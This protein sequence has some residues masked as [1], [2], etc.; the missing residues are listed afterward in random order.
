MS[1]RDF[2]SALDVTL[3]GSAASGDVSVRCFANPD[4][5][6][7]DDRNP[8]CSVNL[9]TGQWNCHTCGAKGG[10][11]DAAVALGRSRS[12][13]VELAKRHDVFVSDREQTQKPRQPARAAATARPSS[14]AAV[15]TDTTP[16]SETVASE[17]SP[18]LKQQ[19]A[20]WR[21]ALRGSKA[22][23][24]RLYELRGWQPEAIEALGLG[25]DG[26]RI[27]FPVR[28]AARRLVGVL[29]Y[30][31][32]RETRK[33]TKM[34]A[35]KGTP[36]ELFPAPETLPADGPVNVVEGESDV[37]A[38]WS[39]G[40]SRTVGVPGA[41][42]WRAEWA[43]R[44][45]GRDVRLFC[46]LDTPGRKLMARIARD[47]LPHAKSVRIV[48]ME[49]KRDDGHDVGAL[50]AEA[51]AYGPAGLA[52]VRTRIE[53]MADEAV[54]LTPP[55][56]ATSDVATTGRIVTFTPASS[57]RH[58]RVR[59][60]WR[61]RVPLG[62]VTT[63]AGQQ[64]LGKSTTMIELASQVTRGDLDGD[65]HGEP[66]AVL[67]VTLEDHV[68]SVVKPRLLA[69]GADLDRVRI[70]GVT[71]DGQDGLI[72]LPDDLPQIE[73]GVQDCGARLLIVDPVVAAL[74]GGIDAYR[75]HDVRRA[76]APL[77]QLAE[78][79]DLA[80]VAIMH[81]T[82]AQTGDLLGRVSGSVAFTAAARSVLA[83]VRDPDDPEG[84]TGDR[85]V[86]VHVKSNWGRL[87]PSLLARIEERHIDIDPP[88]QA[89]RLVIQGESDLTAADFAGR[90]QDHGDQAD[91]DAAEDLIAEHL[92]DGDWHPA[93]DVETAAKAREISRAA[94]YRAA[95]T[96]ETE[97]TLERQ[98]S[99]FPPR[100]MWRC[101]RSSQ[102]AETNGNTDACD[103]RKTPVTTG[104]LAPLPPRSSHVSDRETNGET[105]GRETIARE[106]LS[107]AEA[108]AWIVRE[109]DAIELP[110][111]CPSH[112]A[113]ARHHRPH[114]DT[115]RVICWKCHPPAWL[116]AANE[117]P[118]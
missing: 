59:W 94:I 118:R 37:V 30:A 100:S 44:F 33:G 107:E 75:D 115:G 92:A 50:V 98:R 99:G 2:Y 17:L 71:V 43:P 39:G 64:G 63:L 32:N 81:L 42:G 82:K 110:D 14:T 56:V 87:A 22:T 1:A 79:C 95:K 108:V 84:D 70:V 5:H 69:A 97:G 80:V 38:M 27:M 13:A 55:D 19:V 51:A 48:D 23:L 62:A 10:A 49:S 113:H 77:A 89:S 46:D 90:A 4:A 20:E 117:N 72:T 26:D 40:L 52:Q 15:P 105:N 109:F 111:G 73:T 6:K 106:P 3:P 101:H 74:S 86:I 31:P 60:L 88:A 68:A 16:Q 25:L 54:V 65:L 34:L 78:R 45:A 57:I 36:R 103:E 12:E 83:F 96:L 21:D 18:A 85:R 11:F 61:G 29:R 114:P 41:Q 53:R 112:H 35:A 24:D 102:A 93:S 47:L 8:S 7:R 28:D 66:S 58:E 116:V 67:I 9:D 76:F 104:V 91:R